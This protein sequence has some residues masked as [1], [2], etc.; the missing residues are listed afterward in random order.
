MVRGSLRTVARRAMQCV[1]DVAC[2]GDAFGAT[3]RGYAKS[4]R[5]APGRH[6]RSETSP[7][8]VQWTEVRDPA[9]GASYWWNKVTNRPPRWARQN[10]EETWRPSLRRS[11]R[12]P[13][14]STARADRR[15]A[16]LSDRCSRP[17]VRRR[18][19]GDVH[20][21]ARRRV[22][23]GRWSRSIRSWIQDSGAVPTGEERRARGTRRRERLEDDLRERL[24]DKNIFSFRT[25]N[26]QNETR[27][28]SF[29]RLRR[30]GRGT[31]SASPLCSARARISSCTH[32]VP[33]R[34]PRRRNR[35][36]YL[37]RLP[38]AVKVRS[39]RRL[40]QSA[41]GRCRRSRRKTPEDATILLSSSHPPGLAMF[42]ASA[43]SAEPTPRM[44][45]DPATP[46]SVTAGFG[47]VSSSRSNVSVWQASGGSLD[48]LP[49]CAARGTARPAPRA[50]S[51]AN[52]AGAGVSN[53]RGASIST[54]LAA[55]A[56]TAA[57]LD[58]ADTLGVRAA[59][60]WRLRGAETSRRFRE[61]RVCASAF[62]VASTLD[63]ARTRSGLA[64]RRVGR[65]ERG[66][67]TKP[68]GSFR[69][70]RA[71]FGGRLGE[72]SVAQEDGVP[73]SKRRE[74]GSRHPKSGDAL[75]S[76]RSTSDSAEP[77]TRNAEGSLREC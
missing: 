31:R 37:L 59:P 42:T 56:A 66:R 16:W 9:T 41:F 6:R 34:K 28:R 53:A 1:G 47:G 30:R 69:A 44:T 45:F 22:R 65:D 48:A 63:A 75:P 77:G 32:R 7:A 49:V 51:R 72:L 43:L 52:G 76:S 21:G 54:S 58:A 2:A 12:C 13:P 27:V 19:G 38:A 25:K 68:C 3:H 23:G 26:I 29:R 11:T 36:C 46:G 40:G 17:R 64:D 74:A 18:A 10:R 33:P 39:R 50:R 70:C 24:A 61:R 67:D 73:K 35:L 14:R 5:R 20:L 8:V 57:T 55:K 4:A 60:R 15:S 71:R 62:E